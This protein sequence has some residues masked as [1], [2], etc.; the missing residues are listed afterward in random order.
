VNPI[1]VSVIIPT[2][3]REAQLLEAVGS[4]LAQKGVKIE[5]IVVDDSPEGSARSAVASVPDP[6]VQYV[7]R[8]EPSKGR[9]ALVNPIGVKFA[10][11]GVCFGQPPEGSDFR[12]RSTT[13]AFAHADAGTPMAPLLASRS[14][15]SAASSWRAGVMVLWRAHRG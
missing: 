14:H 13:K 1:D 8:P 7:L 12:F 6:R 3:H 4:V 5:L 15:P 10:R 2:F 11:R 9:P